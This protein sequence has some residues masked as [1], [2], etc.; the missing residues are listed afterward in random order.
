MN[1]RLEILLFALENQGC[2]CDIMNGYACDV[3]SMIKELRELLN[4]IRVEA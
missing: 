3:H 1:K 2:S 4:E